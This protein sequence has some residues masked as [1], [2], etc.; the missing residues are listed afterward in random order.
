MDDLSLW[1]WTLVISGSIIAGIINAL[2]GNGSVITLTLLTEVLG[3]TPQIANGSNRLGILSQSLVSGAMHIRSGAKIQNYLPIIGWVTAGSIAGALTAIY[4]DPKQFAAVYKFM[5]VAMLGLI[6]LKPERWLKEQETK[7]TVQ[8]VWWIPVLLML[9][10]YG[11]FIQMGMGLFLLGLLVP[12]AGYTMR[13]AN[14]IKLITVGVFSM[15]VL[16]IFAWYSQIHWFF[17]LILAAGQAIGGYL[18]TQFGM[19]SKYA[20]QVAYYLLIVLVLVGISKAFK[21]F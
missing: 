20:T 9:G 11:G 6:L 5:L 3:L 7:S 14:G 13:E 16:V 2:A 8:P 10:F 17:G 21:L 18:G 12:I 4:L 19:R 1:Q 15:V